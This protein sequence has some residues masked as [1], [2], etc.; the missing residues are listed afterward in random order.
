MSKVLNYGRTPVVPFNAK[1]GDITIV[2][3]QTAAGTISGPS[4]ASPL[5]KGAAVELDSDMTVKAYNNGLFI[6]FVYNE[7]KWVNGEPR[8]AENQ[9]AAVSAGDLREVGIETIFKKVITLKGK[10][11][12]SIT[13]KK[14]LE[15]HSNGT[16]K[17]TSSS[18]ST[19]S[20]MV[21][22]S[23]QDANDNVVVGIL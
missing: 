10:A 3:T 21:A 1:E 9:S 5:T 20:N 11:S 17:L 8:T 6:G 22:L 12:E 16:V 19:A 18:G 4:V 2:K 23:D 15:F 7:G 13:A 14:Y